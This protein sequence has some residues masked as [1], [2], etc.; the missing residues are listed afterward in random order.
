MEALVQTM[1][2]SKGEIFKDRKNIR[3]EKAIEK[4]MLNNNRDLIKEI[5]RKENDDKEKEPTI[6]YFL[7]TSLDSSEKYKKLLE[8]ERKKYFSLAELKELK[9][10]KSITQ[11]NIIK[12]KN[13]FFRLLCNYHK[14]V[15][16]DF[17][18][19]TTENTEKILKE[20]NMF[21]KS[22]N[23]VMDNSIPYEWIVKSILEYL[24]KLPEYLT[25]N[26]CEEL[27]NEMEKDI[28][29]SIKEFD[30]EALSLI[31][32]KLKFAN[33]SKAYYEQSLKLLEDIESNEEV[34]KIISN[35]FIPVDIK[36]EYDT[37]REN[38]FKIEISNFKDFKNEIKR[39]KKVREKKEKE[40]KE[41]KE[42]EE[43]EKKE[44]EEKEKEKKR[45]EKEE[46][47]KEKKEKE[48]KEKE[49]KEKE[50]KDEEKEE[51]EK[52]KYEK[53]NQV[54][55]GVTIETFLKKFPNLV[56]YQENQDADIFEIQE[57]LNFPEQIANYFAI[58]KEVL[59]VIM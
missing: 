42:K 58:I 24:K 19:G 55:L 15:K 11:N 31:M 32:D 16:T 36:F 27:Y 39:E 57:N 9:D 50:K 35:Q 23:F 20:L 38:I 1:N 17:D 2:A 22:S 44:K 40:E 41:R 28:K 43:K 52:K 14:L 12:V 30:F 4:L 37:E 18:E 56:K 47:E 8:I 13:F 51:T 7:I 45:K 53:S 6:Q 54:K 25:K 21:M 59:K 49:K 29:E 26:D 10:E 33:R 5:I 48:K 3:I 34:R 46:K